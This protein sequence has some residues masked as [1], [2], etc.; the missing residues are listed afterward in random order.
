MLTTMKKDPRQN[1]DR[2]IS[3]KLRPKA[4]RGGAKHTTVTLD[5][6]VYVWSLRHTWYVRGTGTK[7]WSI[8]VSLQPERTRE[9]ILEFALSVE[10][11]E[12]AK[13]EGAV[14]RELENGIRL[15]QEAGWDPES[16]GRAFRFTV[17][18]LGD[19]DDAPAR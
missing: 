13:A 14:M 7:A 2:L 5:G 18:E 19:D 4:A 17:G 1:G 6:T 10:T 15:A 16:R 11:A 3:G 12:G 9:L 8:S